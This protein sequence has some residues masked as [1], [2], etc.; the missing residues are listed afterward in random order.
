MR[1][2]AEVRVRV[3]E[4]T[5]LA[6]GGSVY[7]AGAGV[8]APADIAE[9]WITRGWVEPIEEAMLKPAPRSRRTR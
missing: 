5:Q 7:G 3:T 2:P 1:A 9:R 6:Y 8:S 4:G